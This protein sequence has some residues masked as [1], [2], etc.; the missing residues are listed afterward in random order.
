MHLTWYD[1]SCKQLH[2]YLNSPL[3]SH[4]TI[5]RWS[6]SINVPFDA[7]RLS[8]P[9]CPQPVLHVILAWPFCVMG[10]SSATQLGI[11]EIQKTWK[12]WKQR[13]SGQQLQLCA[14]PAFYHSPGIQGSHKLVKIHK[15]TGKLFP[16][17]TMFPQRSRLFPGCFWWQEPAQKV[18]GAEQEFPCVESLKG[19]WKISVSCRKMLEGFWGSVG[20]NASETEECRKVISKIIA[21]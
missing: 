7:G 21:R 5:H 14:A 4:T 8:H 15:N 9:S 1:L 6:T 11:L 16:K 17:S 2:K 10:C 19:A 18:S 12:A 13:V 3:C 20:G